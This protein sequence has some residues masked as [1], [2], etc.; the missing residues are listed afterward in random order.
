MTREQPS[1]DPAGFPGPQPLSPGSL[2]GK[3]KSSPGGEP[4]LRDSSLGS[5]AVTDVSGGLWD[6][7]VTIPLK[8]KRPQALVRLHTEDGRGSET[9]YTSRPSFRKDAERTQTLLLAWLLLNVYRASWLV[10]PETGF[11]RE[12][13]ACSS[14][15][16]PILLDFLSVATESW[17]SQT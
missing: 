5:T 4:E 2:M 14:L 13:V 17:G 6:S 10:Q 16:G 1:P 12:E 3:A 11:A 7:Q 8:P 9:C 15:K